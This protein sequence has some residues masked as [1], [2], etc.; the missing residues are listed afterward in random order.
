[1][2]RMTG[3]PLWLLILSLVTVG[4]VAG[5][6]AV[7]Y[8]PVTATSDDIQ[9]AF[10]RIGHDQ[11]LT[12]GDLDTYYQAATDAWVRGIFRYQN[13]RVRFQL[14]NAGVSAE[15]WQPQL[16][17]LEPGDTWIAVP[18]TPGTEAFFISPT[19]TASVC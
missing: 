6:I 14:Y 5:M 13:F 9:Q 17:Y 18:A 2:A 4:L 11:P 10:F 8:T 15:N 16:E 1:M 19:Q 12:E 3:N 7:G